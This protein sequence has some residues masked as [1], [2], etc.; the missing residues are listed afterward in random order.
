MARA[1]AS[2]GDRNVIIGGGATIA[3]LCLDAGLINEI[4]IAL[5][6]LVI[7]DG[8]QLF[9]GLAGKV[10]LEPREM[11]AARDVTHLQYRVVK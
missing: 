3:R 1:R 5:R 7:N 2:A 11:R 9:H 8:I 6:P 10:S 4:R